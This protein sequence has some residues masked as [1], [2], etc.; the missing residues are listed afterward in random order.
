MKQRE[1]NEM[2]VAIMKVLG[3]LSVYLS[4]DKLAM[5][6]IEKIKKDYHI[7]EPYFTLREYLFQHSIGSYHTFHFTLNGQR[8]SIDSIGGMLTDDYC[9]LYPLTKHYYVVNDVKSDN[10]GNCEN[11]HCN[12]YLHLSPK[13]D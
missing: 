10:G 6:E 1:Y 13:E 12:H 5:K 11:Y 4:G 7:E 8:I 9:T 3:R 2:Q